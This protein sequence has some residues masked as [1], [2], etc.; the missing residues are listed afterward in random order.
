MIITSNQQA[1]AN[2]GAGVPV[3][4]FTEAEAVTFLAAR[5]GQA[6]AAGAVDLA[7]QVGRLPLALGRPRR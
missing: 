1:V 4:V 3:E 7:D 2:L 5:T 6:D